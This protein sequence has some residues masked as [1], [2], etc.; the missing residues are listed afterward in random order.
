MRNRGDAVS[1]Q[2][3]LLVGF[4]VL[5]QLYVT[6]FLKGWR[7]GNLRNHKWALCRAQA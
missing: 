4:D 6:S 5:D 3:L 2:W 7:G 1:C